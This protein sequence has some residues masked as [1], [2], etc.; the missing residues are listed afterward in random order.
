[1][2][3]ALLELFNSC[4]I[5]D[6]IS[7]LREET[8][9]AFI[10]SKSMFMSIADRLEALCPEASGLVLVEPE[11]LYLRRFAAIRNYN[12]RLVLLNIFAATFD[13]KMLF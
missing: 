2:A 1:M 6:D 3:A 11:Y 4:F 13:L 5:T 7:D 9:S 12:I 8:M 10:T